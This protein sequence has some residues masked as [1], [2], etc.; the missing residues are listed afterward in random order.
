MSPMVNSRKR[1][2]KNSRSMTSLIIV[3]AVCVAQTA[4]VYA[5]SE[6]GGHHGEDWKEW[7]WKIINF[8][9]LF[10]VLVKFLAKPMKNYFQKRTELIE[11]SLQEASE[12]KELAQKALAEVEEK[13]S[14]KDREIEKIIASARHAGETE[15]D[16]LIEQGNEMSERIGQQ[17][18]MN[19]DLELKDAKA[20]LR[21]EASELAVKL[22]EKKIRET[23]T[24][25][26]QL[27]LIEESIRKLE[28]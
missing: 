1:P 24:E 3:I 17:A 16:I 20:A 13:L 10:I 6:E 12:A 11:K 4:I 14:L 2:E 28:N 23:M 18:K 19:I 5:V 26:E 8:A 22:A 7:L 21:A 27:K 9:I 25:A 15:R